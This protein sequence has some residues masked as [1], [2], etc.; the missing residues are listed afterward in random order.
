[1]YHTFSRGGSAWLE[2]WT[3]RER[4]LPIWSHPETRGSKETFRKAPPRHITRNNINY[5]KNTL[6]D[7]LTKIVPI[8]INIAPQINI[9]PLWTL[10]PT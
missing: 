8:E 2:R 6:K 10:L 4:V 3:H 5:E 7:E 1:M 9:T